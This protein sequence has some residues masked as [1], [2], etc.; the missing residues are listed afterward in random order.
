MEFS[1]QMILLFHFGVIFIS[2]LY[3]SFREGRINLDE[4]IFRKL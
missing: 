4:T 2:V 1:V 3:D